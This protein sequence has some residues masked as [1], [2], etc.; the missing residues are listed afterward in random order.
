MARVAGITVE[1]N[2]AGNPRFIK[3]DYNKYSGLLHSFF[4][5]NEIDF[6][7]IPNETT[8]I[9]VSQIKQGESKT[10]KNSKDLFKDLGI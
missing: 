8:K 3:F 2:Y 10:F 4:I 7:L 6:P 1:R 9:A 5:Q